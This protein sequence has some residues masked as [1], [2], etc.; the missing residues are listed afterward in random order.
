MEIS[1]FSFFIS[2]WSSWD[3]ALLTAAFR[4]ADNFTGCWQNWRWFMSFKPG[5]RGERERNSPFICIH[6][7]FLNSQGGLTALELSELE[8]WPYGSHA[9]GEVDGQRLEVCWGWR[10]PSFPSLLSLL[11]CSPLPIPKPRVGSSV[12]TGL[13]IASDGDKCHQCMHTHTHANAGQ[14]TWS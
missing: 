6:L 5:V 3:V 9:P 8:K 4:Q 12:I 13:K 10:F 14:T 11:L 1:C 7:H 2:P